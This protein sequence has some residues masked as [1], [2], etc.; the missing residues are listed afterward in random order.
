MF[1]KRRGPGGTRIGVAAIAQCIDT[2]EA[3]TVPHGAGL[4]QQEHTSAGPAASCSGKYPDLTGR[5]R[6]LIYTSLRVHRAQKALDTDV[7]FTRV[8]CIIQSAHGPPSNTGHL[9]GTMT[10]QHRWWADCVNLAVIIDRSRTKSGTDFTE[11]R[12][13]RRLYSVDHHHLS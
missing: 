9:T 8:Q 5:Q 12:V 4:S 13:L 2:G 1:L 11:S 6:G 3:R 10:P 7:V